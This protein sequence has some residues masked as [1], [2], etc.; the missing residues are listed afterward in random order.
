MNSEV[1]EVNKAVIR[2]RREKEIVMDM[3]EMDDEEKRRKKLER[4]TDCAMESIISCTQI[5]NRFIYD[6]VHFI[7]FI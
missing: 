2:E 4:M 5:I 7:S 6:I 3:K 1:R